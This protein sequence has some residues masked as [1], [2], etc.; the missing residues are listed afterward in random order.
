MQILVH[1]H[2]SL[3]VGDTHTNVLPLLNNILKLGFPFAEPLTTSLLEPA[4]QLQ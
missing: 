2:L 4:A 1:D 3:R